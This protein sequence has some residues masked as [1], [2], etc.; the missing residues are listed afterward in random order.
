MNVEIKY[1]FCLLDYRNRQIVSSSPRHLVDYCMM[2]D[3]LVGMT[4]WEI[5]DY[6][7]EIGHTNL[8]DGEM[9]ILSERYPTW[10]FLSQENYLTLE[11]YPEKMSFYHRI[12][13]PRHRNDR[14]QKPPR[15]PTPRSVH[16]NAR[17]R[18]K[19]YVI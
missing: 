10:I 5:L 15:T 4:G 14:K 13:L 18:L 9:L 7:H 2:L 19:E 11:D 3:D 12:V 16:R 8:L 6:L 1:R 17:A